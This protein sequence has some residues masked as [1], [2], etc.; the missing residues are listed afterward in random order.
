MKHSQRASGGICL[1]PGLLRRELG[2]QTDCV[3][4]NDSGGK[5]SGGFRGPGDISGGKVPGVP[6]VPG[7]GG[8]SDGSG[9]CVDTPGGVIQNR[10]RSIPTVFLCA[11]H[12]K[13]VWCCVCQVSVQCVCG[14]IRPS[15]FECEHLSIKCIV[16]WGTRKLSARGY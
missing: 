4:W 14:S 9:F 13:A 16:H 8:L 15:Q 2:G 10:G 6:G 12:S 7:A 1:C 11:G 5:H 3:S